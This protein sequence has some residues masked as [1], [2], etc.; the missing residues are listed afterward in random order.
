MRDARRSPVRAGVWTLAALAVAAVL[1]FTGRARAGDPYVRWFTLTTPHYR[2]HFHDGLELIAQKTATV[3]EDLYERLGAE[4]GYQPKTRTEIVI[5]DMT[6]AANGLAFTL[7]YATVLLYA[8]APDDMSALGDYDDWV[9]GLVT[10]ELTHILHMSNVSGLPNVVNRVL[11]PTL[12]PNE[13]QPHWIL[14]GLAV[15]TESEHTTGG[16]LR[17]TQFDMMLRADVL[18]GNVARL[19]EISHLP[20]RWPGATLWY[21]YGGKFVEWIA[22]IYGPDVFGAVATDYGAQVVSYG[23]NRAIRR[24]TSRT[25]E[26]LYAG[27][28]QDLGRR[29]GAQREAVVR[30]G[31]R[32]GRRLTFHGRQADNPRYLP[33]SCGKPGALAYTRSDKDTLAGIY[34]LVPGAPGAEPSSEL[35]ARTTGRTLAYGPDCAL[36]FDGPAPSRRQYWFGDLHRLPPGER[37][38][39]H[40]RKRERVTI[41]ARARDVDVSADGRHIVYVTNERGTTTLR[42]AELDATGRL[43]SERR[44]VPSARFE[45]VFTPRFS[46]D[47]QRVAFGT[48]TTGGYRDIRIVEIASGRLVE[49]WHDRALDQQPTWSHD[50]KTLFFVSDRSGIANVYAYELASGALH[51]VTNVVTGAYMPA[52]SP[53]GRKLVYAG[54]TTEGFDLFELELDPA[55]WL[56]AEPAA[57][58]RPKPEVLPERRWPVE[59]YQPLTTLAPRAIA[60]SYGA[61]TFGDALTL[62]TTG[63]DAIGR[64]SFAAQLT[65]ETRHADLI[66]SLDYFYAGLPFGLR[67]TG[68]RSA[69]PRSDYRV[70]AQPRTVT[71]WQTGVTTGVDL[72]L[73]GTFDDQAIALSYTALDWDHAQPLGSAL[74]PFALLPSEPDR[75]LLASVHLGYSLSTAS[76]TPYAISPEHGMTLALGADF[77]DGAWGSESTLTAFTGALT[78][79]L[80]M[81]WLR[82]HVLALGLSGG[83]AA[84]TYPRLSYFYTGGFADTPAL[85]A[86]TT[87][88]RQSGFVLRGYEAAQFGGSNFN[89]MNV[90]YRFPILYVDRGLSTLPGFVRTLSGALF[91]DWG[92]AYE[93]LDLRDPWEA[94]HVGVGAELHVDLSLL[95]ADS[96]EFR[97]GL[98][99]GLDSAA[100]DRFESYF[101]L[102][103]G[104]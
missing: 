104:F 61:G 97:Y 11:G 76:S 53:D 16:R 42:L 31:L 7:P 40:D 14:E 83:T 8:S 92:G 5:T 34:E 78:A 70:G 51:Q 9:T 54:Y 52:A 67:A 103:S 68:F 69:A 82:H 32:E 22:S 30:R 4:L 80:S 10:H 6:D 84:G 20:R 58:E 64:H 75:G 79:Y 15:A 77:A 27:W 74:D 47:G 33:P 19:D 35:V 59:E 43:G 2:V 12:A 21:L 45:Q 3:V 24:A 56:P 73:P 50:G 49:L 44:L 94:Y 90:E 60:F 17:S 102:A 99:R 86:F 26:E 25:Y 23:V 62:S 36:Y 13:D 48:W 28:V 89:L 39:G 100:R 55:R 1:S 95:F 29:Y 66:A 88:V 41:G 91:F 65:I 37:S 38:A 18:A 98:A 57:N 96:A 71:E 93:T 72:Q 46:P 101:V 81:P 87:G 85:D 63:A